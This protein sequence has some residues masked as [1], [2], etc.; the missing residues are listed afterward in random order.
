MNEEIKEEAPPKSKREEYIEYLKGRHPGKFDPEDEESTYG[1]LGE[2]TRGNDDAQDRLAEALSSDPRLAQLLS[3]VLN[4]KRGAAASFARYFGKDLL[5]AEE[6]TPEWDEIQNAESERLTEMSNRDKALADYQSAIDES[7]PALEK[8]AADNGLDVDEFL[9]TVYDKIIDPIFNGKYTPELLTL[10]NN[11][12][13][14]DADVEQAMRAGKVQAQN[15]KIEQMRADKGDGMP[16]LGGSSGEITPKPKPA[17]TG[18]LGRINNK[19]VWDG[20]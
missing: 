6:G 2:M 10:L 3:D 4:K 17:R 11:A 20:E 12:I 16:S 18:A 9:G 13:N 14:Y 5:N 19:S 7:S 1:F 15:K 8:F